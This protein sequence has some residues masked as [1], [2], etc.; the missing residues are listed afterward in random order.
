MPL[1]QVP[2]LILDLL[3]DSRDSLLTMTFTPANTTR[4]R[5]LPGITLQSFGKK[6][7]TC[8]ASDSDP[9]GCTASSAW[10]DAI[11]TLQNDLFSGHQY[12]LQKSAPV[13]DPITTTALD[14]DLESMPSVQD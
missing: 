1:Y 7:S 4:I 2:A 10:L 11:T 8:R 3:G 5:P 14:D 13:G 9:A 12:A 6:V